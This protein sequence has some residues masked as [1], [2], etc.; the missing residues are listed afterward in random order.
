MHGVMMAEVEEVAPNRQYMKRLIDDACVRLGAM[1]GQEPYY[2]G[3]AESI[4]LDVM[5]LTATFRRGD[6]L[7]AWKTLF[8]LRDKAEIPMVKMLI[9]LE[10]LRDEDLP[11]EARPVLTDEQRQVLD[12]FEGAPK[13]AA[14]QLAAWIG[15]GLRAGVLNIGLFEAPKP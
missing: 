2:R 13:G 1:R 10:V 6:T 9:A 12:L 4:G 15:Q 14:G 5:T 7:P 3:L 8:T 11:G